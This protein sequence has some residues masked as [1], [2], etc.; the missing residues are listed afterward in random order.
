MRLL[1]LLALVFG[2]SLGLEQVPIGLSVWDSYS[3]VFTAMQYA[4]EKHTNDS[5][6]MFQFKVYAD[7][8]RTIDAYKVNSCS[9]TYRIIR[10]GCTI[11]LPLRE[12]IEESAKRRH[13]W[14][15]WAKRGAARCP[16]CN[17]DSSI[18]S[19]G[20][21]QIGLRG[22]VWGLYRTLFANTDNYENSTVVFWPLF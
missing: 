11:F 2:T 6:K 5:S 20:C 16:E 15:Y 7:R 21:K 12:T 17:A 10:H 22:R 18:G 3:D 13:L 14:Q 9:I 1:L 19:R 4:L 8:I